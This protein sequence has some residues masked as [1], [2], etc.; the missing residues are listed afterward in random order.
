MPYVVTKKTVFKWQEGFWVIMKKVF[1]TYD[2]NSDGAIN[3]DE[4]QNALVKL[5]VAPM[6]DVESSNKEQELTPPA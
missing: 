2:L 5:G 1:D 3:L 6:K 4:F